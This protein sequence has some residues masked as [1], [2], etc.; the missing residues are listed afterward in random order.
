MTDSNKEGGIVIT[1]VSSFVGCHL[2]LRFS[3]SGWRVIA[4]TRKPHTEYDPLRRR[5]FEWAGQGIDWAILDIKEEKATR[6]F[7]RQYQPKVWVH[8]AGH[9]SNYHNLE[10]DLEEGQT[11]N[12]APLQYIYEELATVGCRGIIITGSSMEYSDGEKLCR[13]T[14]FCAPATPYGFSKLTET[15]FACYQASR[16]G[17]PT[18]IARLFV[19]FGVLDAPQK[20]IYHVYENL[21]QG[22]TVDLSSCT[23]KRDIIYIDDVVEA[24]RLLVQDLDRKGWEVFNISSGIATPLKDIVQWIANGL[25]APSQLL[26][27]GARSMRKGEPIVSYGCAEKAQKQLGWRPRSPQTGVEALLKDMAKFQ[28]TKGTS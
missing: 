3:Q 21:Q 23:Q 22:K 17:L 20:L 2:A 6:Q 7:I 26:R 28:T 14:D 10:Y 5:R 19:P 9:A 12:V 15:L 16:W 13:E 11:T 25:G 27:F 1:G 24:Y 8:H 4:V 18:R